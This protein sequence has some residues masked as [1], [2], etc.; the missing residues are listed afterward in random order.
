MPG[1]DD[2][3]ATT[4]ISFNRRDTARL[5]L[6]GLKMSVKRETVDAA[7]VEHIISIRIIGGRLLLCSVQWAQSVGK[8]SKENL[9]CDAT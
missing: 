2:E 4:I 9:C 7:A 5:G 8:I 6:I 3:P 1:A